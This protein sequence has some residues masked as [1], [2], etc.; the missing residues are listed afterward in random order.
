MINTLLLFFRSVI[1]VTLQEVK[2]GKRG[3][4]VILLIVVVAAA[5]AVAVVVNII[6]VVV[7]VIRLVLQKNHVYDC[8]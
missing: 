8:I 1:D 4:L 2:N 5:A 3:N 6:T 7:T